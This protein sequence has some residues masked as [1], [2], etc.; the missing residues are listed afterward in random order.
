MFSCFKKPR[1]PRVRK[2][3]S[4]HGR[5]KTDKV[6]PQRQVSLQE[7]VEEKVTIEPT[8]SDASCSVNQVDEVD[9]SVVSKSPSQDLER[10]DSPVVNGSKPV[11]NEQVKPVEPVTQSQPNTNSSTAKGTYLSCIDTRNICSY[12]QQSIF[13]VEELICTT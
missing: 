11:E 10:R 5:T 12:L 6:M 9:H 8:T 13:K 1:R 4:V 2:F 3:H 7:K